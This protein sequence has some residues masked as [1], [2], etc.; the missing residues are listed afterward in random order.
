MESCCAPSS[1]R[2][3]R[4]VEDR[5]DATPASGSTEGMALLEAG[6]FL[7]GTEDR[8]GFP[9][10]GEGPVRPITLSPFW[11]DRHAVTNRRFAE[12]VEATGHTTDAERFGWSFVFGGLLPE[13]FPDTRAAVQAP[14]WRQV[15]AAAWNHPEG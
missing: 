9:A 8:D 13:G 10:D 7:M 12:F 4:I 11:I 5:R 1:G 2:P 14:W 15:F 6:E 3:T